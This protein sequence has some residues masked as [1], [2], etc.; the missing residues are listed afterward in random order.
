MFEPG[1]IHAATAFWGWP[2]VGSWLWLLLPGSLGAT[3]IYFKLVHDW[4]ASR[5]GTY[6]FVSPIVAVLI[7][8]PVLG[9]HV[10]AMDMI[11]ILPHSIC[12]PPGA[13]TLATSQPRNCV[14][15]AP[16]SPRGVI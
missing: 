10:S 5:A 15:A 8:I 16:L 1:A 9:E 11:G 12:R 13:K 6:A 7:A 14:S 4:G 2:A 3:V